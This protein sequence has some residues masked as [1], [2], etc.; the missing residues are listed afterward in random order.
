MSEYFTTT[1]LAE[2]N[3]LKILNECHR[4][5][6]RNL[7]RDFIE[8][9]KKERAIAASIPTETILKFIDSFDNL[10][11]NATEYKSEIQNLHKL[12]LHGILG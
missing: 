8:V 5:I 3:F 7:Y 1:S 6:Q 2:N 12:L 9:G 4:D 11:L 10:P